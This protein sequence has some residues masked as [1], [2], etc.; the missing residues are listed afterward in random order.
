M[1]ATYQNPKT[2]I[3][4]ISVAQMIA[5]SNGGLLGNGETPNDL[6]GYAREIALLRKNSR[7]SY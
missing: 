1:K 5:A 3:I 7:T 4:T 6:D 2:D